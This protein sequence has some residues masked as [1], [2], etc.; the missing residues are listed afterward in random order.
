[1][2]A[3]GEL[4]LTGKAWLA[5]GIGP[6]RE[7]PSLHR[8]AK[9][10]SQARLALVTTGGFVPPGAPPFSTGK[11]G[12]PSYRQIPVDIDLAELEIFHPHYDHR[13][14]K[15]DVNIIFPLPLCRELVAEGI[16]GSLAPTHYSFMG[17]VPLTRTLVGTYAPALAKHLEAEEVDATLLVPA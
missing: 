15:D 13:P 8:L 3:E 12:D 10:L 1:M 17:Y 6:Q 4:N 14:V 11:W 2:K 9:P 7:R 5:L 16:V